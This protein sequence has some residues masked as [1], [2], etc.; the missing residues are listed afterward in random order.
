MTFS[1]EVEPSV[2]TVPESAAVVPPSS[3]LLSS[4]ALSLLPQAGQ[5]TQRYDG[6]QCKSKKLFH[7]KYFLSF[8]HGSFSLLQL[9]S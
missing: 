8:F 4:E 3:P 9:P 5:H 2:E 7:L 1:I 6:S